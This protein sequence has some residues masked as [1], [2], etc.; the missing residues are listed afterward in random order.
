M[1]KY[2]L[3][4]IV[5]LCVLCCRPSFADTSRSRLKGQVFEAEEWSLPAEGWVKDEH[6]ADKWCLWTQEQ[7]VEKKRSGGQSLRSPFIK[8]DRTT[9]EEGAP[10][11]HTRITGLSNGLYRVWMN[12]P[13]R[14]IA[15]SFDGRTWLPYRAQGEL[16]LGMHRVKD[17]SFDLWV[18]D[19]YA[20]AEKPGSCY[21]DYLRFEPCTPPEI[22]NLTSFNLPDG[23]T[24]LSWITDT[25]AYGCKVYYGTGDKLDSYIE[26]ATDGLRNHAAILPDLPAGREFAAE[27]RIGHHGEEITRSG[28]IS[29]TAG[30]RPAPGPTKTMNPFGFSDYLPLLSPT[31]SS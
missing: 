23:K 12:N 24:Q 7:D 1:T 22:R 19:R 27:I 2:V 30:V 14:I 5:T 17:G 6:P 18:D 31:S 21:Y 13:A 25:P 20:F 15:L 29:F 26:S 16:D 11:L 28:R 3:H 10:P 4:T 8:A 9:P